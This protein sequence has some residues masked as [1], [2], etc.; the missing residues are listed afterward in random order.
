MSFEYQFANLMRQI[1]KPETLTIII[2]LLIFL[3]IFK[4]LSSKKNIDKPI[5]II[6][7]GTISLFSAR[8]LYNYFSKYSQGQITNYI[9]Q[10]NSNYAGTLILALIPIFILIYVIHSITLTQNI[11]QSILGIY[12]IIFALTTFGFESLKQTYPF[13]GSILLIL[14]AIGLDKEIN[15]LIKERK[16]T[17]KQN[18]S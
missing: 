12:G 17:K 4:I 3:I 9:S 7:A 1:E 2:S 11:R 6:I 15:N 18:E 8:M 5:S 16:K 10:L 14:I 13:W